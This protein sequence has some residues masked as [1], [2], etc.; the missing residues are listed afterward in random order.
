MEKLSIKRKKLSLLKQKLKYVSERD[1]GAFIVQN[2]KNY[3]RPSHLEPLI[4]FFN[5]VA[6]GKERHLAMTV[7]PRHG[8]TE[9][10]IHGIP[11]YLSKNREKTVAYISYSQTQSVSKAVKSH[12]V[13]TDLGWELHP[14]LNNRAEFRIA[15]GGGILTTAVGGSLTGQG[16]DLLIIDDPFS[17]YKEAYSKTTRQAVWDWFDFVAET[18]LEPNASTLIV[19]TRWHEDDLIGRVV[20]ERKKYEFIR[21]PAIED[22]LDAYGKV[23]EQHE[24]KIGE[25]LWSSRYPINK[26][27]EFKEESEH[28]FVSM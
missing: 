8:K 1:L 20:K 28:S 23:E 22:G 24:R 3:E 27:E 2:N 11:Y 18:R 7:P 25:A 4:Q 16:V 6:E 13:I 5:D 9:T 26:L 15:E 12:Q 21:I 10:A 14:K 19:H 17:N